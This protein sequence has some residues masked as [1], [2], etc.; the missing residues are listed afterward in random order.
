M[1]KW[2]FEVA[3]QAKYPLYFLYKGTEAV[4]EVYDVKVAEKIVEAMNERPSL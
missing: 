4:G 1:E 2:R 3:H